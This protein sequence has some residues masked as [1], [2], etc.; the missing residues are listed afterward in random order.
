MR[1]SSLDCV[2]TSVVHKYIQVLM[3]REKRCMPTAR[4]SVCCLEI[5]EIED[6]MSEL[7]TLDPSSETACITEHPGFSGVCLDMWVLQMTAHQICHT[8]GQGAIARAGPTHNYVT[9]RPLSAFCKLHFALSHHIHCRQYRYI[10]YRQ[11]TTWCWGYL[12]KH[13]R[14]VLP[15][16]AVNKIREAFPSDGYNKF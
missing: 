6:K 15:S 9:R 5:S 11:L 7:Q 4:E 12:G 8:H 2:F 3:W 10:A 14:V 1:I 13:Q 16:C